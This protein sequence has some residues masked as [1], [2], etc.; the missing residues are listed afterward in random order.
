[1]AGAWLYQRKWLKAQPG[2]REISP[3]VV[4]GRK[5]TARE[6]AELLAA[7]PLAVLDLTAESNAPTP[8]REKSFYWNLPL[9]DLVPPPPDHIELA[10]QFIYLQHTVGR[11]VY[12]QCQL[13][14][15][16]SATIAAHW[17]VANHQDPDLPAAVAAIRKIH[18]GIVL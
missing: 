2:W 12:I 13:G 18:P 6:A 4:F 11:R 10:V 14:L 1:M 8:F 7:G 5:P 16:R 3:G 17:R 9:L 15:Q